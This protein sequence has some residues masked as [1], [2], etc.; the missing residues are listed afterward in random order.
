MPRIYNSLRRIIT[1][2]RFSLCLR[3]LLSQLVGVLAVWCFA[4][5]PEIKS[6]FVPHPLLIPPFSL[7]PPAPAMTPLSNT[8]RSSV[9]GRKGK[10]AGV[11]KFDV[12]AGG[13][14]EFPYSK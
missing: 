11:F 5:E 12:A 7:L 4:T 10:M 1:S 14:K 6:P 8:S 2:A 3:V 13:Q 9:G